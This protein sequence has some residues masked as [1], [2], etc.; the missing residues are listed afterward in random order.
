LC[1]L[2]H[3][4]SSSPASRQGK[5]IRRFQS[6]QPHHSPS[7]NHIDCRISSF[8][9][10]GFQEPDWRRCVA[11][12]GWHKHCAS[13]T[14]WLGERAPARRERA[15]PR[16]GMVFYSLPR[17]WKPHKT[18]AL[19][20]LVAR[21]A[22]STV[23]YRVRCNM[24]L[25]RTETEGPLV[26]CARSDVSSRHLTRTHRLTFTPTPANETAEPAWRTL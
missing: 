16:F 24:L 6:T 8:I 3:S 14:T 26:C 11:H 5:P 9:T 1:C 21:I 19:A 4:S 22:L 10:D 20:S 12:A 23:E 2:S 17:G 13:Q 7:H 18:Q 15:A 25:R